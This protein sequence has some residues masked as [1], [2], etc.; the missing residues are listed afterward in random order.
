MAGAG[1]GLSFVPMTIAA[2]SGVPPTQAGLAAGLINTTRQVGG[3]VGLAVMAT[4]ASSA[5]SHD[6]HHGE[7]LVA[8]LTTGYDRAFGIGAGAVLAGAVLA[9]ALPSVRPAASTAGADPGARSRDEGAGS[10]PVFV[11]TTE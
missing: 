6:L 4:F 2:T 11:T 10:G 5:A 1:F 3:A 8:A 7:R 9:L